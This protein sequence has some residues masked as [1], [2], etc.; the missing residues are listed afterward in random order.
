VNSFRDWAPTKIEALPSRWLQQSAKNGET[1]RLGGLATIAVLIAAAL[2]S[3]FFY[4]RTQEQNIRVYARAASGSL[5]MRLGRLLAQGRIGEQ[6]ANRGPRLPR[7]VSSPGKRG[8]P[9]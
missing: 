3:F 9:A 1:L 2:V 5:Q 4:R 8:E 6:H 7:S